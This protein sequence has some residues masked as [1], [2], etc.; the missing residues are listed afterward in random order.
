M[1]LRFNI[2]MHAPCLTRDKL[3]RKW[4]FFLY[5]LLLIMPTCGENVV[6]NAV[7]ESFAV[8]PVKVFGSFSASLDQISPYYQY[9]VA[10]ID[11]SSKEVFHTRIGETGN[12]ELED[13]PGGLGKRYVVVMLNTDMAFEAILTFPRPRKLVGEYLSFSSDT[14]LGFIRVQGNILISSESQKLEI[15]TGYNFL[16]NDSD[17]I[18]DGADIEATNDQFVAKRNKSSN[19]DSTDEIDAHDFDDDNDGIPDILDPDNDND[20]L[21]DHIDI[22]DNQNGTNDIEE[23]F[24]DLIYGNNSALL[25]FTG[26]YTMMPSSLVAN[27]HYF[28]L[29]L[30]ARVN[31]PTSE[32]KTIKSI[33]IRGPQTLNDV[34]SANGE[35]WNF[36]LHDDGLSGDG[37][38][39]DFNWGVQIQL[40]ESDKLNLN[41][42]IL[43]TI[44]FQDDTHA[45]Y[46]YTLNHVFSTGLT[47]RSVDASTATPIVRWEGDVLFP[48]ITGYKF[49]IILTEGRTGVQIHNST[50]LEPSLREYTIPL[51]K[52]K[53]LTWYNVV[54]RATTLSPIHGFEGDSVY[55]PIKSFKT[56]SF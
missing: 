56:L 50:L 23:S 43:M 14:S 10:L 52:V 46:M 33:S 30:F 1:G 32:N 35:P 26:H 48:F 42:V 3:Q 51:G 27:E 16:D 25:Y 47:I 19:L 31:R 41:H 21:P 11:T 39:E 13:L 12:F 40:K 37:H 34:S 44:H 55:S 6:E 17:Q 28:L 5:A 2:C 53:P 18:P 24:G 4:V 15:A 45:S 29:N 38:A 8:V 36:Q 49:Q 54:V 20:T 7:T 9:T 22:D